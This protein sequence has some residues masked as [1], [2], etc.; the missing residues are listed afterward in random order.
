[1]KDDF[2]DA[3]ALADGLAVTR[4]SRDSG[5][6][7]RL[8]AAADPYPDPALFL[9]LDDAPRAERVRPAREPAPAP[10][11]VGAEAGEPD[12]DWYDVWLE[13]DRPARTA[14]EH[15]EAD[16]GSTDTD[17]DT[18]TDPAGTDTDTL[19]TDGGR[20]IAPD[21]DTAPVVAEPPR[22]RG[23]AQPP[24]RNP[25]PAPDP[26][27]ADRPA[28][29]PVEAEVDELALP[30]LLAEWNRSGHRAPDWQ[31]A[32]ETAFRAVRPLPAALRALERALGHTL[33]EPLPALTDLPAFD[34]SAM[35]GWAVSGPGPWHLV[36]PM[37]EPRNEE[38]D[39]ERASSP[40]TASTPATAPSDD[41][42]TPAP[43]PATTDA[44][45][46]AT[47]A[48]E[49]DADADAALTA[50]ATD[51][52]VPPPPAHPPRPQ[53]PPAVLAGS[54]EPEPLAD[55]LAVAIATGAR[56][57]A[58]TSA[59]LR[60]ERGRVSAGQLRGR[61]PEPGA[62]IRPR[63]QECR[64]GTELLPAGTAVTPAVLGLAAAAGYDQL[65]VHPRPRVEVLVLGDELLHRGLPAGGR[66]R[67]ALGPMTGPWLT[68]LGAD[69]LV[70]RRLGDDAEAL[71]EAVS[72]S[73]AHLVVTTGSTAAG[74]ADQLRPVL[75]RLDARL[76]VDGVAVRPGHPMLLAELPDGRPLVGLPGNPLAAVTGL[77]TLAAP[78]LA[79]LAGRELLPLP[80]VELTEEVV[81]H[82][83]DTRVVP[84]RYPA[85]E[86]TQSPRF[87][88]GFGG[89]R[90]GRTPRARPVRF[91]G[92]AMLR[93]LAGADA[94]AL[95]PPGGAPLGQRVPLVE[96][97]R[98]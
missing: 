15:V 97:P 49:T 37:A 98:G 22:A 55:G 24:A 84:V 35:D 95:V 68:M 89:R 60:S 39:Q 44:D 91:S 11:P 5:E 36:T 75:D 77:L 42:T 73:R 27:P 85:A 88:T 25:L 54:A 10:D 19:D 51:A 33:A 87:S 8:R 47:T 67:D 70:T 71:Y 63:G 7:A 2:D 90:D 34:T 43:A 28:A 21:R 53:T 80:A 79:S 92:P 64:S 81:G 17:T 96:L 45:G 16:G 38:A 93:G 66:I 31:T 56:V 32:R 48:T 76:R 86:P 94:L 72:T 59:V 23:T 74:P 82:E 40:T 3:L 4:D 62:D 13:G 57:P 52:A 69:V 58:A 83:T 30:P 1:M 6:A 61:N 41:A 14:G 78:L 18:D 12:D 29:P 46:P 50:P 26:D 20:D 9:D 65:T